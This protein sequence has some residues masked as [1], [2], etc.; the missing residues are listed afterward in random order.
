MEPLFLDREPGTGTWWLIATMSHCHF[1][2]RNGEPEPPYW[3]FRSDGRRWWRAPMPSFAW[4]RRANL[5]TRYEI[6]DS[7]A[8]LMTSVAEQKAA[9]YPRYEGDPLYAVSRESRA[10]CSASIGEYKPPFE[11]NLR[12]FAE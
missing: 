8:V 6:G 1:W 2:N 3:A 12:Q 5:F 7:D 10:R 11:R 4:G 9:D